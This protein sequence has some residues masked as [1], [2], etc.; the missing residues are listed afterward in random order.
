M[1]KEFST[2]YVRYAHTALNSFSLLMF[3]DV[4]CKFY[5]QFHRLLAS[6]TRIKQFPVHLVAAKAPLS[7]PAVPLHTETVVLCTSLWNFILLFSTHQLLLCP[8]IFNLKTLFCPSI[9]NLKTLF[10]TTS[11]RQTFTSNR[12]REFR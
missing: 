12:E 7:R 5:V 11:L 10:R 4:T 8:S 2:L 6:L 9:F 1:Y 3:I